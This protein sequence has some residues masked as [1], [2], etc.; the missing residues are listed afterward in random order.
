MKRVILSLLFLSV[1]NTVAFSQ[2]NTPANSKQEEIEATQR[3]IEAELRAKRKQLLD[4]KKKMMEEQGAT[5]SETKANQPI[6]A[7]IEIRTDPY[8]GF[9]EEAEQI[10][11]DAQLRAG[12]SSSSRKEGINTMETINKFQELIDK[13]KNQMANTGKEIEESK[14]TIAA[15]SLELENYKLML[16]QAEDSI[17]N[18][19]FTLLNKES[20]LIQKSQASPYSFLEKPLNFFLVVASLIGLIAF[21]I[22]MYM[23][24]IKY[25]VK[26]EESNTE[27][28]LLKS[29]VEKLEEEQESI[30]KANRQLEEQNLKMESQF[31][32]LQQNP[33]QRSYEDDQLLKETLKSRNTILMAE[34]RDKAEIEKCY[35]EEEIHSTLNFY[36]NEFDKLIQPF[37]INKINNS[38]HVYLCCSGSP[39]ANDAKAIDLVKAALELQKAANRIQKAR[40]MR[41]EPAFEMWIGVHSGTEVVKALG[42]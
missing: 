10:K 30:L 33:F 41:K 2:W 42:L 16:L 32:K 15:L 37:Q 12:Q 3:R 29:T 36:F 39:E 31:S 27:N 24:S 19:N 4:Q 6:N 28:T 26:A 1:L 13:A 35:S 34:I 7:K 38:Q 14:A 23:L 11:K 8:P 20:E 5:S 17:I 18:L 9:E 22:W 21:S 40:E 25:K